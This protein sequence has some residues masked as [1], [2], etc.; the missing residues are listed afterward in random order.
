MIADGTASYTLSSLRKIAYELGYS[1]FDLYTNKVEQLILSFGTAEFC[2]P[3]PDWWQPRI[4]QFKDHRTNEKLLKTEVAVSPPLPLKAVSRKLGL[5]EGYIKHRYPLLAQQLVERYANWQQQEKYE[6]WLTATVVVCR[7]FEENGYAL[8]CSPKQFVAE[9]ME[10][11]GL[12]RQMLR[13]VV[14]SLTTDLV[15]FDHQI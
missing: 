1:L 5:S 13:E 12:P 9:L 15:E 8:N 3:R 4:K 7:R 6:K 2:A 10:S 14:A 11:T